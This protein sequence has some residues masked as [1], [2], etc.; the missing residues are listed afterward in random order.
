MNEIQTIALAHAPKGC[1]AALAALWDYDATLGRVVATTTEPM[2]G[3]MRLTWWHDRMV[4]LDAG[5]VSAE[6]VIVALHDVV[7][8]Y[9]VTGAMLAKL[10]EGWE[11]LLDPLPLSDEV[12]RSYGALRGEQLFHVSALILNARISAGIGAA[13]ALIDFATHCSDIVTAGRAH[14]LARDMLS[15]VSIREP[16]VLRILGRVARAKAMRPTSDL[17]LPVSRWEMARAV[18][19]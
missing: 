9:D 15:R 16:K 19:P 7:R 11:V 17:K 4:G 10:V 13:W 14:M 18:L 8:D 12:L 6:P 2:I 1:R 5:E 3:Q